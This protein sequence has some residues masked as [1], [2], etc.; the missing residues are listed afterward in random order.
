MATCIPGLASVLSEELTELRCQQVTPASTSAVWFQADLPT[1]LRVILWVRTAH[2]VLELLATAEDIRDKDGLYQWIQNTIPVAE[3]LQSNSNPQQPSQWLT[4][5]VQV[6]RNQVT[7]LPSDLTHSHFTALT[8]K[9][10]LVD[11]ARELSSDRPSVS[12][13]DPDVPLVAILH[14]SCGVAQVSLYRQLHTDSLHKRGYRS[15]DAIH[16]AAMKESLA[17]GLLRQAGFSSPSQFYQKT[18]VDPMAGSGTLLIEAA[19]MA[20]NIAPGLVSI[21]CGGTRRPPVVRWHHTQDTMS[22]WKDTLREA[23]QNAKTGLQE[24]RESQSCRFYGN[25]LHP[26]AMQLFRDSLY[27]AGLSDLVEIQQGNCNMYEIPSSEGNAVTVVTNP[28]WG[29]RLETDG[30]DEAW[31]DL[32][33]FLRSQLPPGSEAWVLSGNK[34]STRQLKWKRTNMFPIQT[35]QQQLRWIQYKVLSDEERNAQLQD[36]DVNEK[37]YD[38][39]PRSSTRTYRELQ[40]TQRRDEHRTSKGTSHNP[41]KPPRDSAVPKPQKNAVK[42]QSQAS[43]SNEWLI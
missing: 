36:D 17:A 38:G 10:A 23:T 20:A 24:L 3:I 27:L 22:L 6:I 35:G 26:S 14:G 5:S 11:Q 42:S 19:L 8:I 34:N 12:L 7:Q 37:G 25:E 32:R 2:K 40:R 4:L 30:E 41:R 9:N 31:D 43:N 1:V 28:P 29:I 15:G 16:K 21:K 39:R 13:D 18:I 33:S